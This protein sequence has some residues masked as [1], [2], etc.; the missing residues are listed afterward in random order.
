MP[1]MTCA[2]CGAGFSARADAVYCSPACRQKAHRVRA[3]RRT[4]ALRETL[5]RRSATGAGAYSAST[6]SL[7]L[8]VASSMQRS[9]QQLDRARELCRVSALRLQESDAIRKASLEGRAGWA[10]KSET[11]RALW[12]GN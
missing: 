6:R 2:M 11:G 1:G 8:S 5:R 10:A 9:R 12:R 4:A 7:Q 3:A